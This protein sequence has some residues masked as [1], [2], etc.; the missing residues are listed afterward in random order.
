MEYR[1]MKADK[2]VY[3]RSDLS[4]LPVGAKVI[5]VLLRY[6]YEQLSSIVEHEYEVVRY[7]AVDGSIIDGYFPCVG[8]AEIIYVVPG[9]HASSSFLA[10]LAFNKYV[11]DTP[12]YRELTRIMD[13][14]M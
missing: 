13:E 3:H 1:T 4:R 9:T 2:T 8:E 7:K 10:Y 12:L 14:Q 6:S 5:K 11:L